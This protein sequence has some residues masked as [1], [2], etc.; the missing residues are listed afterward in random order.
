MNEEKYTHLRDCLI[1]DNIEEKWETTWKFSFAQFLN[2]ISQTRYNL[3]KEL[4][5]RG[6][7]ASNCLNKFWNAR[8]K[9]GSPK[10]CAYILIQHS[11]KFCPKCWHIKSISEFGQSKVSITGHS[12]W[13]LECIKLKSLAY[14]RNNVELTQSQSRN[15]YYNHKSEYVKRSIERKLHTKLAT[16][17]WARLDI[18]KDMYD[19]AEGAHVDHIIPLRG[20]LVCGLHVENNLQYLTPEEN[21]RKGNKF[22]IQ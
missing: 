14:R 20:E 2:V 13:C 9:A 18:I 11:L 3:S 4:N 10:I 5:V 7:Y 19:C 17:S 22:E 1:K 12:S 21:L 16:P 15:N 6:E 8:P